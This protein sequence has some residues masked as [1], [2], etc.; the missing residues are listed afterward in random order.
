MELP[1]WICERFE[2]GILFIYESHTTFKEITF[3]NHQGVFHHASLDVEARQTELRLINPN[4]H[5]Y[6]VDSRICQAD[7][8]W[9]RSVLNIR[10]NYSVEIPLRLITPSSV[11]A[12]AK[13]RIYNP[14]QIL[15][16]LEVSTD[17]NITSIPACTLCTF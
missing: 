9:H 15:E 7:P 4:N 14:Y 10:H 6:F 2:F 3:L 8:S 12:E 11:P 5:V 16:T 1:S 13:S 17:L